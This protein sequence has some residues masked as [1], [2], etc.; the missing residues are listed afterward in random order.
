[1]RVTFTVCYPNPGQRQQ[2]LRGCPHDPEFERS[3]E[4]PQPEYIVECVGDVSWQ[5]LLL[6]DGLDVSGWLT[7]IVCD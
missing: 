7:G 2:V 6:A 5:A 1:M 4:N 3:G